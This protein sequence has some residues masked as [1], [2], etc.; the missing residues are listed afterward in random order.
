[1]FMSLIYTSS[2][3]FIVMLSTFFYKEKIS[4]LQ[5]LGFLFAFIGVL[6]VI[7]NGKLSAF[8]NLE[9]VNK[10][11]VGAMLMITVL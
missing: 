6:I 3:I 4:P 2:S 10:C 11:I 9:F 1:M 8:L 7:S 5:S